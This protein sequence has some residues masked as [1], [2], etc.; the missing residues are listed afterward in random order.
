[1]GGRFWDDFSRGLGSSIETQRLDN[2]EFQRF[3]LARADRKEDKA[4]AA[5]NRTEDIGRRKTERSEDAKISQDRFDTGNEQQVAGRKQ[6]ADQFEEN[7]EFRAE[8]RKIDF[9]RNEQLLETRKVERA[10][11]AKLSIEAEERGVA[12]RANTL[13]A[14]Q[15]FQVERE[16]SGQAFALTQQ[17]AAN[18]RDDLKELN[19][20]A[21]RALDVAGARDEATTRAVNSATV[22]L[23]QSREANT[24][25]LFQHYKSQG[26]SDRR[27]R[28][29]AIKDTPRM[30]DAR[31]DALKAFAQGDN[32][33]AVD[34]FKRYASITDPNVAGAK[35]RT[36]RLTGLLGAQEPK[37]SAGPAPSVE[38]PQRANIIPEID[39]FLDERPSS[40]LSVISNA[41]SDLGI[42]MPANEQ[43]RLFNTLSNAPDGEKGFKAALKSFN[44]TGG[45]SGFIGTAGSNSD[46]TPRILHTQQPTGNISWIL[47]RDGKPVGSG[48][49][50]K[51]KGAKTLYEESFNRHGQD[52]IAMHENAIKGGVI[53]DDLTVDEMVLD[54][55]SM[56]KAAIFNRFFHGED[57]DLTLE[58]DLNPK[59]KKSLAEKRSDG[60]LKRH[61]ERKAKKKSLAKGAKK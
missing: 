9:A 54:R 23:M 3:S 29:K 28:E 30:E 51:T 13:L 42:D 38:E 53:P 35:E 16:E 31:N 21:M 14:R 52:L 58:V 12:Q 10:E 60:I 50:N 47:K 41:L 33:G 22:S 40:P 26:L 55:E 19:Q 32:A 6:S 45:I 8:G 15:S 37:K 36:E 24:E 34:H 46:G 44:K 17:E 18:H 61:E 48:N 39:R 1:M 27:A 2:K 56:A 20:F 7:A 49:A 59:K 57:G 5:A 25:G 4:T 43:K 11:D